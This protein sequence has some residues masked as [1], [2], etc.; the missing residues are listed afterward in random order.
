[1]FLTEVL[2][3][4][5]SKQNYL[6]SIVFRYYTSEQVSHRLLR[7][8]A[9]VTSHS[10][11]R[12]SYFKSNPLALGFDLIFL[13]GGVGAKYTLLRRSFRSGGNSQSGQLCEVKML[14][15]RQKIAGMLYAFQDFL[16]QSGGFFGRKD[17]C[18]GCC[19]RFLF[20]RKKKSTI[21]AAPLLI[22]S[23]RAAA[24]RRLA[25][26]APACGRTSFS[27]SNPLCWASI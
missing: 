17:V 11:C 15:A 19:C 16:T 23:P 27:K 22:S 2:S 10:F 18:W 26:E 1:M 13:A 7:L 24:L 14:A 6:I 12:G 25:S 5:M 21:R 8:F 4:H 9:K 20:L 3:A